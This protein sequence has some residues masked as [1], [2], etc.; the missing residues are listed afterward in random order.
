MIEK[1]SKDWRTTTMPSKFYA[2]R[3]GRKTGVFHSWPECQD[4]IKGYSGAEYKSFKSEEEA[5]DYLANAVQANE[6]AGT[7][8]DLAVAY[9]DGSYNLTTKEY[10]YGAVLQYKGKE[11]EYSEKGQDISLADMR[12]VAGEILG[13]RKMME[14]CLEHG[15][16]RLA[17]YYDYE[18]IEKWCTGAWQAKKPGTI[19][20]KKAYDLIKDRLYVEFHKVP[21]HTGIELNER[22]DRL[23]KKALGL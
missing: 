15:I 9:V 18:G 7:S 14:L 13:A 3:K 23:A 17:L 10:S 11:Y 22:V 5:K 19:A 2:V 8:E 12:N 20:Y 1:I 4:Q 21:A 16:P 6:P